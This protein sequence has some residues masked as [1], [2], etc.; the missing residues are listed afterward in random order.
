[1]TLQTLYIQIFK[2]FNLDHE[3]QNIFFQTS[4]SLTHQKTYI[5][6]SCM[7][8]MGSRLMGLFF[9]RR[10]R[11]ELLMGPSINKN[12][13]S[14]KIVVYIMKAQVACSPTWS[15]IVPW[16]VSQLAQKKENENAKMNTN[17]FVLPKFDL[18]KIIGA[19][20]RI[21]LF[22]V[23]KFIFEVV[24]IIST[25][26]FFCYKISKWGSNLPI[27]RGNLLVFWLNGLFMFNTL[28]HIHQKL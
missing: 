6:V 1:M 3:M 16:T 10:E 9:F 15:N 25:S 26:K 7:F 5:S 20:A 18:L 14:S 12:G 28:E 11:L 13:N 17:I 8:I 21:I 24:S 19:W 27:L 23:L 4:F 22:Q 2:T